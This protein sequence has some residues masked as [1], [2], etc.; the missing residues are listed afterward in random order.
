MSKFSGC[1]ELKTPQDLFRKLE[2]DLVRIKAEPLNPY[3]VFDFFVT[4]YH[5]LDWVYPTSPAQRKKQEQS[6]VILQVCS[7]LANGSKHFEATKPHHISVTD[8]EHHHGAFSNAFSPAFD[9][10]CLRVHLDGAAAKEFGDSVV[11]TQL[12]EKVLA[13]WKAE[14]KL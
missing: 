3:P 5:M 7:H 6:T 10:S 12:A 14:L 13:Y 1:F 9:I 2:A 8:T 11:A 4:A